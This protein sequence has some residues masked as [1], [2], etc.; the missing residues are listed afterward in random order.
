LEVGAH[1][2][3]DATGLESD[4]RE[5]RLLADLLD[6]SGAGRNP[7]DRLDVERTFEV[8]GTGNPPGAMYASGSVT[9]GGYFAGVD[10]FLGLQ[11]SALRIMDDLAA[12]GFCRRMGP[13]RAFS[14]WLRWARHKPLAP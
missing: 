3:V 5:H 13:G 2:V 11:Y 9:L 6:H 4:I 12:R 8:R 14:Q 10:T 1:F 7:L